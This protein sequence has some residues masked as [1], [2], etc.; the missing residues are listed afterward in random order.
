[1]TEANAG[2]NGWK[3]LVSFSPLD[4]CAVSSDLIADLTVWSNRPFD[5]RTQ[6]ILNSSRSVNNSPSIVRVMDFAAGQRAGCSQFVPRFQ[7]TFP[8][9]E[10]VV[11][12]AV[13]LLVEVCIAESRSRT[14]CRGR[15]AK[16]AV[17]LAAGSS[18]SR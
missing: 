16:L 7:S 14:A 8:R 18:G 2:L 11:V 6:T 5:G 1:M 13:E 10:R 17:R 12:A 15:L 4:N 9:L 3:L